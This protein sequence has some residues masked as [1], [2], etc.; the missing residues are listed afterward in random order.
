MEPLSWLSL[1]L[2]VA[3]I[4]LAVVYHVKGN[5]RGTVIFFGSGIGVVAAV[6]SVAQVAYQN[7]ESVTQERRGVA[8]YYAERWE[9]LPT[10]AISKVLTEMEGKTG[11]EMAAI[12]KA[13]AGKQ[14]DI[15]KVMNFFERIGLT[16]KVSYSDEVALCSLF[17]GEAL[18]YY[19]SLEE[20]IRYYR[21]IKNRH[22]AWEYFEWLFER[23]EK[24][25][26]T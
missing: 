22:N 3:L 15:L 19:S 23:W 17:R 21:K 4:V 12:L 8:F 13:D 24:G 20:Y 6:Y 9:E 11:Q 1:I 10:M 25:C 2:G 14:E 26:P 18:Q 5:W 16:A 7:R